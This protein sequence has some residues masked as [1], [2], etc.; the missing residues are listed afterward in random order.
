MTEGRFVEY[1]AMEIHHDDESGIHDT[2]TYMLRTVVG[3][4][5]ID[6]AGRVGRELRRYTSFDDG[7]TWQILD[8]WSQFRDN[9][10]AELVEENQKIIKLVFAPSTDKTWNINAFNTL[11]AKQAEYGEIHEAFSLN[12]LTFDSTLTVIQDDFFSLVDLRRQSERYAKNIGLVEKY[13]KDLIIENF[14]TLNPIKG[15][16]LFYQVVNYGIQ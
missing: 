11:Q 12:G 6:N 10:R 13:H 9:F 1:K 16:E 4:I 3:Q 15:H 14:D 8:V 7:V 2:S 5:Y